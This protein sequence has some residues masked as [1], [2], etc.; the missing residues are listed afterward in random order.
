MGGI[1]WDSRIDWAGRRVCGWLS[2]SGLV[3]HNPPESAPSPS[4]RR[5]TPAQ[6]YE[7]AA[8][9]CTRAGDYPEA[10]KAL[11]Q[12]VHL[13]YPALAAQEAALAAAE[14]HV[15]AAE[16]P[17]AGGAAA[18]PPPGLALHGRVAA[19][20]GDDGTAPAAAAAAVPLPAWASEGDAED[21]AW[22]TAAGGAATL[23]D[24]ALAAALG[25][26]P[27]RRWPEVAAALSL[28]FACVQQGSADRLDTLATLRR[29]PRPLLGAPE[30]QAALRLRA[31][32]AAGD[33]VAL[34]RERAQAPRLVQLVA[35]AAAGAARERALAAMAVAYRNV[36]AAAACRMLALDTRSLLACLKVLADR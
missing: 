36:A 27:F 13:I 20:N 35:D 8:D 10:L 29:L 12:L 6:V 26:S 16:Q 7:T 15:A 4:S 21:E 25:R 18:G 31:A 19:S 17:A 5:P 30:V 23:G 14:Q 28:Y 33:W 1:A 9:V 32:L 22:L 34:F 2:R 11:Q 24:A 3:A